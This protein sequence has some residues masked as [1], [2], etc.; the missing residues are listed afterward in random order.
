M[1]V[2]TIE[3]DK[4]TIR[5]E[6]F[7]DKVPKT[8][9]NFEKLAGEGFYD[10]LKFH[11][12]IPDFMVQTGCP[13]GTGTGGPGYKFE[14]EF[15]RDLKHDR[16]GILSMANAGPN[17]NGSQFF[18]THVATPW[19]DGKHSVFGH[20]LEGQDVV[21]SIEQGDAMNKVTISEE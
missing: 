7:E 18:I 6:L 17:T 3:T 13:Q 4:G 15:H 10:G 14:D 8:V 19:L 2:A 5:L 11:R 1:K 20:V 12:V 16:P 9:A 21:D